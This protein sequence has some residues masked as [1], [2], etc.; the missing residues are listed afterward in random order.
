ME[1]LDRIEYDA[2]YVGACFVTGA[3]AIGIVPDWRCT[4]R[5]DRSTRESLPSIRT[6]PLLERL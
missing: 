3:R 4:D 2:A 1:I 6:T 5:F